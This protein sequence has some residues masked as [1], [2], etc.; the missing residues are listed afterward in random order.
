[1]INKSCTRNIVAICEKYLSNSRDQP[2]D[3]SFTSDI[4]L[5]LENPEILA[6]MCDLQI[7]STTLFTDLSQDI[8]NQRKGN[9]QERKVENTV[10]KRPRKVNF[11]R[12]D[13][14]EKAVNWK[15]TLHRKS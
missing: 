13:K 11:S 1:M 7:G 9:S 14:V 10:N 8:Q 2:D 3:K 5:N 4:T 15:K 12:T 6:T